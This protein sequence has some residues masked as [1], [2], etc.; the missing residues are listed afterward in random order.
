[1]ES[2]S[3]AGRTDATLVRHLGELQFVVERPGEFASDPVT[4]P[5]PA[6]LGDLAALETWRRS[7]L[8]RIF[9]G[10]ET[11]AG[12]AIP[13]DLRIVANDPAVLAWPW[14]ALSETG[15]ITRGLSAV[16]PILPLA[17]NLPGNRINVLCLIPRPFEDEDVEYGLL[18]RALS[19]WA[20]SDAQPIDLDV[21]RPPTLAALDEWLSANPGHYHIVHFDGHGEYNEEA[22]DSILVFEN[23]G[24]G[25]HL[26]SAADFAALMARHRTPVVMMNASPSEHVDPRPEI[27][28]AFTAAALLRAGVRN[29]VGL[30]HALGADSAKAFATAFYRQ[31]CQSGDVAEATRE[32]REALR[33]LEGW[34][35]PVLYQLE[36]SPLSFKSL[37]SVPSPARAL[38]QERWQP[39]VDGWHG[40]DRQM[41]ILDRMLHSGLPQAVLIHGLRD[42]GKTALVNDYLRWFLHTGPVFERFFWFDFRHL[43]SASELQHVGDVLLRQ[44]VMMVWDRFECAVEGD[45]ERLLFLLDVMAQSP[46]SRL[47][48]ISRSREDWI[49][50]SVVT[51]LPL[52]GNQRGVVQD[53]VGDT[54]EDPLAPLAHP[55]FRQYEVV[56][57]LIGLHSSHVDVWHAQRMLETFKRPP[58]PLETFQECARALMRAGLLH[59]VDEDI[60][61]MYPSLRGA[62]QN[63][64]PATVQQ[65]RDFVSYMTQYAR[66]AASMDFNGL[67]EPPLIYKYDTLQSVRHLARSIGDGYAQVHLTILLVQVAMYTGEKCAATELAQDLEDEAKR[68][69]DDSM[70]SVAVQLHD[71]ISRNAAPF[72]RSSTDSLSD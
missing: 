47:L 30:G 62:L 32:G 23:T 5:A 69:G 68:K 66:I 28:V 50:D 72:V 58:V 6:A 17:E 51:R 12:I 7:V 24:S 65:K 44:P 19:E 20:G 18:A 27:F 63:L 71:C 42:I 26:V 33:P 13:V 29:V 54:R 46:Q 2:S 8:D 60:Y 9:Q 45:R 15:R 4:L 34:L 70:L 16:T 37:E 11:S 61:E 52:S 67:D 14:E 40:R 22:R 56:L 25:E 55:C 53:D 36:G 21:L 31:L 43:K 41:R 3:G 57:Q 64:F 10:R 38:M 49:G 48:I 1:M 35:A 59:L 39:G